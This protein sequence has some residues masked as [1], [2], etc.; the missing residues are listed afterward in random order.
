MRTARGQIWAQ[1]DQHLCTLK[2][3]RSIS[4][5]Q[6]GPSFWEWRLN[7]PWETQARSSLPRSSNSLGNCQGRD[8]A[9]ATAEPNE[10]NHG[11]RSFT[12]RKGQRQPQQQ[13]APTA[14]QDQRLREAQRSKLL[15]SCLRPGLSPWPIDLGE[16]ERAGGSK[17]KRVMGR[18]E[19]AS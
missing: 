4:L 11:C 8:D 14:V 18:G 13:E 10:Q 2:A 19:S 12:R 9:S 7:P 16:R 5:L 3:L 6:A 15:R 17:R 1:E